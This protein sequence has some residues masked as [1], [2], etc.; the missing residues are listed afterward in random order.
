MHLCRQVRSH[1]GYA[2]F[3]FME[4]IKHNQGPVQEVILVVEQCKNP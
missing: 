1:E 2:W 4:F 3:H